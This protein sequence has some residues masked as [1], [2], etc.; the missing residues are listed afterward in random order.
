MWIRQKVNV[1]SVDSQIVRGGFLVFSGVKYFGFSNVKLGESKVPILQFMKIHKKHPILV[2][3]S[4]V[5]NVYVHPVGKKR[6]PYKLV[7]DPE[8]YD[9]ASFILIPGTVKMPAVETGRANLEVLADSFVA[10]KEKESVSF[11]Y[12]P[13]G[14]GI[15]GTNNISFATIMPSQVISHLYS[16]ISS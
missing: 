13:Q 12:I 3:S 11:S 4:A 5:G 7:E 2:N 6:V 10:E 14:I 16:W 9:C 15:E 1:H 8:V